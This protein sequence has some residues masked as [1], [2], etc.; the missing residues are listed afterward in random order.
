[1]QTRLISVQ[2]EDDEQEVAETVNKYNLLA[3]PV[4]DEEQPDA[5]HHHRG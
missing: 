3:I 4:V 1:M 2:P 5:G